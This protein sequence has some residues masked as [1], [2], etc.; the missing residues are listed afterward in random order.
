MPERWRLVQH[1]PSQYQVSDPEEGAQL[2]RRSR[3]KKGLHWRWKFYPKPLEDS[4][5]KTPTLKA[6]KPILPGLACIWL[7]LGAWYL[8][9]KFMQYFHQLCLGMQSGAEKTRYRSWVYV[10]RLVQPIILCKGDIR[11][12]RSLG[13][14]GAWAPSP[15]PREAAGITRRLCFPR[16]HGYGRSTPSAIPSGTPSECQVHICTCQARATPC[17]THLS[18]CTTKPFVPCP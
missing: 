6:L 4:I 10:K 2:W 8:S 16:P 14:G 13:G 7:R 18:A 17:S 12:M 1:L 11:Q 15:G 5:A 9:C 3:W